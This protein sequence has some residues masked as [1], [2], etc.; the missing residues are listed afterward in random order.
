MYTYTFRKEYTKGFCLGFVLFGWFLF[1]KHG[2]F[3]CHFLEQI[4]YPHAFFV[5]FKSSGLL[6]VFSRRGML[7]KVL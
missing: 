2:Y 5:L 4:F 7:L 3:I 6:S 1:P